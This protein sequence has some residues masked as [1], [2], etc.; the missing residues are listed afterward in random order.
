MVQESKGMFE[1]FWANKV[2]YYISKV[3]LHGLMKHQEF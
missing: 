1:K 2:R 3:H